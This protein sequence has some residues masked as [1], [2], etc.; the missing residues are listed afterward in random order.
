MITNFGGIFLL[1]VFLPF[2]SG[3]VCLSFG[4]TLFSLKGFSFLISYFEWYGY[5]I[6]FSFSID[7][8]AFP[9]IANSFL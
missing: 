2:P 7:V 5:L 6:F 4:K 9:F 1:E 8:D 3:K